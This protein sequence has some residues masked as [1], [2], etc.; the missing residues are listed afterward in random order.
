MKRAE[1]TW[2]IV[3]VVMIV[4]VVGAV[5]A[6]RYAREKARRVKCLSPLA[7]CLG[8]AM[9]MYSMD[10]NGKFPTSIVEMAEYAGNP[11]LFICPGSDTFIP[12]SV[13]DMTNWGDY[14]YIYWPDGEKTPVDYPW[15]YDR[16]LSHHRGEGI[17]V[18]FVG[19]GGYFDKGAR[20]L[21]KFAKE[22]PELKIPMPED[23][24]RGR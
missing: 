1:K 2:I 24:P 18:G 6:I 13:R 8:K 21:I 17:N 10:H 23:L 3:A 11:K 7:C 9:K 16:K 20:D 4:I 22:H 5:P 19:G 15:L 12:G 14:I